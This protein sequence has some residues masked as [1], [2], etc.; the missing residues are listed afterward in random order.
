MH[1]LSL[2]VII[3]IFCA[4]RGETFRKAFSK[5]GEVRSLLSPEVNVMALTA[6]ATK[7]TRNHV[8]KSLGMR[9]PVIVSHSPNKVNIR[10]SVAKIESSLEDLLAP[11]ILE[12]KK[13]RTSMPRTIIFTRKYDTCGEVYT[14]FKR[15]LKEKLTEPSC[16]SN[17]IA[18]FRLVDMFTAC[19]SQRTLR[20]SHEVDAML[21]RAANVKACPE[22]EKFIL[23][24]CT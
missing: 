13:K 22:R 17:D 1:N 2:T 19:T 7:S 10:Y 21:F 12:V 6:T 24:K 20:F 23:L 9:N 11:L 16:I 8:C 15:S 14:L 18:E 3:S 5:I 4:Y